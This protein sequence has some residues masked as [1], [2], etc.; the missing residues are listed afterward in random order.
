MKLINYIKTYKISILC[1]L[2]IIGINFYSYWGIWNIF[3]QQD[4]WLGLG[5]A[6]T[7]HETGGIFVAL[8]DI[9]AGLSARFL[10]LTSLTNYI[11]FS[12]LGTNLPLYGFLALGLACLNGILC[13]LSF[14]KLTG[15]W[16]FGLLVAVLF[17]TNNF[18]YQSIA[19]I[20]TLIPSQF[21]LLFFLLGLYLYSLF[22]ENRRT[23][24]LVF[25]LI[26]VVISL[27]FKESVIFYLPVFLFLIW[28][29]IQIGKKSFRIKTSLIITVPILV[30]L[31]VR[32][33]FSS[34]SI[35][36]FSIASVDSSSP[37]TTGVTATQK[38]A[39]NAFLLPARSLFHV[40]MYQPQVY[41]WIYSSNDIHYSS[42]TN[43]FV[44]E[45]I[46]ADSFSLLVS[47]YILVFIFLITLLADIKHK[48][49][50]LFSL[51]SFFVSILPF[52]I[53]KNDAAILDPRYFLFPALWAALL[54]VSVLDSLFFRINRLRWI[55]LFITCG[56]LII[57]GSQGIKKQLAIDISTGQY[58][59]EILE[60]V[61]VIKPKLS[62]NNIFYFYTEN[63]GFYEFQSGF[64]QTL[65]VWLYDSG[66]IPRGPL[67]D[68]DYWS[69]SYEGIK[70]YPEG[71]YGYFMTYAT[72]VAS[73]RNNSD[74]DLTNVHSFYWEPT[75]HSV[76]DVSDQINIKLKKDLD[77]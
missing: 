23:R 7:R 76:R 48:R 68:L 1:I 52:T 42:Q 55:L 35:S 16:Q 77:R 46:I 51:L 5:G 34:G 29:P 20:G 30:F 56:Y 73:L 4:E 24:I 47:F 12:S 59:K 57:Y 53:F 6:I 9:F 75:K 11:V 67:T 49:L 15:Y 72:L 2:L 44:V 22:L 61:S 33:L 74:I 10:P 54:L 26:S 21:S 45:S 28:F 41:K 38:I 18:V 39:Y 13:Y 14:K 50:I 60:T 25:S 19:W 71:K 36:D 32:F 8:S 3:F 27:L 58:R 43:G 17:I 63:T 40:F 37:T 62:T 31:L 64:G 66:K 70:A 65:A 69:L